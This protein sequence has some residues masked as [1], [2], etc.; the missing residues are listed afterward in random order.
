MA[1]VLKQ[2]ETK[3]PTIGGIIEK[4]ELMES[5]EQNC[6]PQD[7]INYTI[8]DYKQFLEQRRILMAQKI[9][10]YYFNL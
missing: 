4:E 10:D 1:K 9:K 6:I 3:E 8:N 2:I 7:F 5:F